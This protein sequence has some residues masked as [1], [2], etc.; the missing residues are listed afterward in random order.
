[1]LRKGSAVA[2][3]A[4]MVGGW[5]GQ[6]PALADQAASRVNGSATATEQTPTPPAVWPRP[7]TLRTQG[8]FARITPQVTLV[9][10]PDAAAA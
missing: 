7:Q 4:T 2:V 3:V 8:Q 10:G 6:A 5:L 9:A 1:M